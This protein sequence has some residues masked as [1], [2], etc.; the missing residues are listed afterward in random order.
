M[1]TGGR[2]LEAEMITASLPVASGECE[3][4]SIRMTSKQ[5]PCQVGE[6]PSGAPH[7]IPPASTPDSTPPQCGGG[8]RASPKDPLKNAANYKSTGWRKD[9]EHVLKAYYKCM[10]PPLR[11]WNG[12]K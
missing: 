3:K 1:A 4:S 10:L 2:V 6:C 5:T 8:A 11:R 7:N 12:P 9:L